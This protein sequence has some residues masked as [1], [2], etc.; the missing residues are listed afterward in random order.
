MSET[1]KNEVVRV[2]RKMEEDVCEGDK[3][4]ERD[5]TQRKVVQGSVLSQV[6]SGF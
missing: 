4:G 5:V 6:F 2:E 1:A 3:K